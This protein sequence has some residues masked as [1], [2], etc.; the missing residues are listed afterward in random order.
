MSSQ[1]LSC[2]NRN[3]Y[4]FMFLVAALILFLVGCESSSECGLTPD[5]SKDWTELDPAEI[6]PNFTYKGLKPSC[7]ACPPSVRFHGDFAN[8]PPEKFD[9]E[10]TF[11]VK[12]GTSNNLVIFFE[13]GGACWDSMNCLYAHTYS[14]DVRKVQLASGS[15]P[16]A[17]G[18][19][20]FDT[21]NSENP[22]KDW[23]FVY[24]P[25]CT[26]DIHTGTRDTEYADHQG[27][28]G[29][30]ESKITIRHRGAVNVKVVLK[31]VKEN[32]KFPN[33]ILVT[34]SSAGAYGIISHFP[35]IAKAY[36]FSQTYL[37]SDAGSG[38]TPAET[39]EIDDEK[40]APII[41]RL[42]G[43]YGKSYADISIDDW[44]TTTANAFPR[45]KFS[46][47]TTNFD[48]TQI[49][50]YNIM[51]HNEEGQPNILNPAQWSA[52]D[53]VTVGDDWHNQMMEN[54]RRAAKNAPNYRYYIAD[55]TTHMINI[56][57]LFYEEDTAGI[58]FVDWIEAM[59]DDTPD[60]WKNVQFGN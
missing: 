2:L 40:W 3:N 30:T 50:F 46:Q 42:R 44:F 36:P 38:V 13:D 54:S 27:L 53:F 9:P 15:G 55:G 10:Y 12:G 14:E 24:I 17:A 60:A 4:F 35:E 57:P 39:L 26:G 41:P 19:G 32:F 5:L 33:K 45:S 22:F 18:S 11:F 6:Y 23:Y 31:W 25:Y 49:F 8:D 34:G 51:L 7:A 47:Y 29:D 56:Y 20:I 37:L 43:F 16:K 52:F 48:Q 58:A 28:Y 1:N 21:R 59:L